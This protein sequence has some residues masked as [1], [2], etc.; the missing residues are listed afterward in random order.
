M[1]ESLTHP[2]EESQ[3]RPP[4]ARPPDAGHEAA[5][6]PETAA[7]EVARILGEPTSAS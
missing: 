5:H 2:L 1:A 4:V 7:A 6:P 3:P